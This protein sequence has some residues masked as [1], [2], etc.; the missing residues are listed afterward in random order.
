MALEFDLD[1]P[2]L[3]DVDDADD[4]P[5]SPRTSAVTMPTAST[6]DAAISWRTCDRSVPICDGVGGDASNVLERFVRGIASRDVSK[7]T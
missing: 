6:V 7:T 5:S 2:E 4:E 1:T 3:D